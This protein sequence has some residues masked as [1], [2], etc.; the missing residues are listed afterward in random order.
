MFSFFKKKLILHS[1]FDGQWMAL[2]EVPD[3]VFSQRLVGDGFAIM[4]ESSV[5]LSPCKG[6]I[7]Q[8][9]PTNHAVGIVTEEGLEVLIHIGI[10]T[11]EL[12][13]QGF[14]RLADVGQMV[15]VGT[16]IVGISRDFIEQQGK[17]LIT[18]IIITNGEKVSKMKLLSTSGIAGQTKAIE[19][20]LK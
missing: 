7:V 10:D 19:I 18:P 16:P 15:E 2:D 13:G 6:K 5:L 12:K 9:F 14:E 11:V 17:S 3:A 8:I 4:P 1:P 20:H